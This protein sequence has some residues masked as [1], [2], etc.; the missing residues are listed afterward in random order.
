MDTVTEKP[1]A[2]TI[3][4]ECCPPD[5]VLVSVRDTGTG[6]D[7]TVAKHIFSPFYTTKSEGMGMGLSISKTIIEAHG[8]ELWAQPNMPQGA[9]FQFRLPAAGQG[10]V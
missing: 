7:P 8:G 3:S 1:R 2:L 4:S 6:V 5:C 9:I 10:V